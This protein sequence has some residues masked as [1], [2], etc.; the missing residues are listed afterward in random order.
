MTQYPPADAKTAAEPKKDAHALAK[1]A[2]AW[3][4]SPEGQREI[5]AAME[6]TRQTLER[7]RQERLL[8]HK[9]LHTPLCP[10]R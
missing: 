5:A 6:K 7:L 2:A 9:D 1:A 10:C 3:A 4:A 8:S